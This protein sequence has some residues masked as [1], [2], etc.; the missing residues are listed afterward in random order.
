MAPV[1]T[2]LVDI[3]AIVPLDLR[4]KDARETS[5]SV[6]LIPAVLPTA[7]TVSSCLM[8]TNASA[9][10]ASQVGGVR[11]G[12]VSVSHSLVKMEGPVQFPAAQH[13]DTPALVSLAILDLTVKEACPVENCPATME[14]VVHLPHGERD[15]PACQVMAVP[16]VSTA[17]TKVALR[18]PAGMEG[19]AL[20]RPASRSSTA[21]V[22]VAGQ[23]NAASRAAV[24]LHL[25]VP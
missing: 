16:S 8:T 10:L 4:G 14:V 25:P 3:A 23:V 9:G 19:C 2:E 21:S 13:W 11:A 20:R 24:F 12:S 18:S 15:V 6:S 22:P 17:A 5:M 7:L 1:W